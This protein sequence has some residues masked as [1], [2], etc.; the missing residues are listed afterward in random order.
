MG[1]I[2]SCKQYFESN[3]K[4]IYKNTQCGRVGWVNY[5]NTLMRIVSKP[6]NIMRPWKASTQMTAFSPP[7]KDHAIMP[8][9][10][11]NGQR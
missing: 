8:V 10:I 4:V 9:F 7:C 2:F 6:A 11:C 5:H 3:L 1:R